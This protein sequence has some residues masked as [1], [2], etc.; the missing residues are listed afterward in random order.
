M[1]TWCPQL[2]NKIQ[3]VKSP[4]WW[5]SSR[6]C[7]IPAE[8]WN[9]HWIKRFPFI[10]SV[11]FCFEGN[12]SAGGSLPVIPAG[13]IQEKELGPSIQRPSLQGLGLQS[14]MST[15]HLS[16]L[17]PSG[18][19]HRYAPLPAGRLTLVTQEA[20]FRHSQ[21]PTETWWKEWRVVLH[22]IDH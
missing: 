20:P 19:T 21:E 14:S 13:Q 5:K 18:H 15:S 2:K 22:T 6:S 12:S 17:N 11:C 10:R 4:Y 3:L 7:G 16:P 8:K 1:S 9:P